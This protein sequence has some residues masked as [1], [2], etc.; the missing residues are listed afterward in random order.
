MH[1]P[2]PLA[3]RAVLQE[4]G[5]GGMFAS[6]PP[7]PRYPFRVGPSM[8]STGKRPG[9]EPLDVSQSELLN[10]MQ[11]ETPSWATD[12]VTLWQTFSDQPHR[13][14]GTGVLNTGGG[15][16]P[17]M[18]KTGMQ[19]LFSDLSDKLGM[20]VKGD[21]NVKDPMKEAAAA[22]GYG[23]EPPLDHVSLNDLYA[24]LICSSRG[25]VS[26][27]A[28]AL[29]DLYSYTAATGSVR[30]ITPVNRVAARAA[31]SALDSAVEMSRVL[32]PT[33]GEDPEDAEAKQ[34]NVLKFT[35]YTSYPSDSVLGHVL[36]PSL[37]P[38]VSRGGT[39]PQSKSYNIWGPKP[40]TQKDT[41]SNM[42]NNFG[43][44]P[45]RLVCLG[46]VN[47]AIQWR[48][49]AQLPHQGQL[50][51][52]VKYI[53]FQEYYIVEPYNMNPY[54][55][56]QLSAEDKSAA[57]GRNWA[58]IKRWDPRG[59]A[60]DSV[61]V[62]KQGAFGGYIKFEPTMK[63][64]TG[65]GGTLGQWIRHGDGQGYVNERDSKDGKDVGQWQWNKTWG[66]QYS[67]KDLRVHPDFVQNESRRNTIDLTG[68]RLIVSHVL[69]RCMLNMT[70]KQALVV[71]DAIFNRA[72]AVPGIA[73]A[74]LVKDSNRD[75]AVGE[76]NGLCELGLAKIVEDLKSANTPY[77]DV[78]RE[79]LLEHERQVSCNGGDVNLFAN[80][81]MKEALS[82]ETMGIS[83]PYAATNKVLFIRY[84]RAG[85]G[86]RCTQAIPVD[87]D[88]NVAPGS[89][90]KLDLLSTE[91]AG[92]EAKSSWA[93]S[94]VTKQEFI[95][96]FTSSPL[97]SESIRRLGTTAHVLHET[98][99]IPLEVTIMDP[100]H[101]DVFQELE[102]SVNIGQSLLIEV[103]DSDFMGMDFLG[104]AWLPPLSEFGARPKD[105]V[106]PLQ[107]ANY[108]P[109][110]ENG[111]SRHDPK[112]DLKDDGTNPN[113]KVTG[114][115]FLTVSWNYPTIEGRGLDVDVE[116]WLTMLEAKNVRAKVLKEGELTKYQA[117][118]IEKHRTVRNIRQ[119]MVEDKAPFRL[120]DEFYKGLGINEE[121]VKRIINTWFKDQL[122]EDIK[123]RAIQQ[124]HKHSGLLTV[125]IERAER[126]RRADAKTMR[127]CD[128]KA[129]L[130]VRNDV[131]GAWR[132]AVEQVAVEAASNDK[133]CTEKASEDFNVQDLLRGRHLQEQEGYEVYDIFERGRERVPTQ[134]RLWLEDWT[135]EKLDKEDWLAT[136]DP[137]KSW[138]RSLGFTL[139]AGVWSSNVA[140]FKR[141]TAAAPVYVGFIRRSRPPKA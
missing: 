40:R 18:H 93:M 121:K 116:T 79:I 91:D 96:C 6:A 13:L 25:T 3:D 41:S 28:A 134:V 39:E 129:L 10:A 70:N 114:D 72:G 112:K 22:A 32:A 130:W 119:T 58:N 19:K 63:K 60:H 66:L 128:P 139:R 73:Q 56:V 57:G 35:V 52:L 48:G 50:T 4:K 23:G 49:S 118:I 47:M 1:R 21:P 81:Y 45:N 64:K 78:T 14:L 126:L 133:A 135:L 80:H 27:K 37:S 33:W 9:M 125:R 109:D 94:R 132:K 89:E 71:A 123:S 38:Y 82:L 88:G 65:G 36:I 104:E 11:R 124:E 137:G 101:D 108:S 74:V 30:H 87:P 120:K 92:G 83:D 7:V 61:S 8:V 86:Q 43:G 67:V 59:V 2:L 24:A 69:Q 51:V 15:Y 105:I 138:P 26:E 117:A 68:V 122:S 12:A 98:R 29:F 34:N 106:L 84:I 5:I 136:S 31:A 54:I 62:T 99:P 100:H 76:R 17:P 85:D 55:T 42:S 111:P 97:L 113:K 141:V 127:D 44:E 95:A 53:K 46:E 16:P 90:V 107:T 110:A 115:I 77:V 103:W 140:F 102:E 20:T 75:I 131:H